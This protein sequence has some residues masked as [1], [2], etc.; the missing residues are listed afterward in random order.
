[1]LSIKV[2]PLVLAP[3]GHEGIYPFKE[4]MLV[5]PVC[6]L[7]IAT[8]CDLRTRTIPDSISVALLLWAIGA[9]WFSAD[10]STWASLGIGALLGLVAGALFF[11]L[12][13]LGGGD[14]KLLTGLGAVL[15]PIALLNVMFWMALAGGA[16]A[17]VAQFRGRRDF[18]YVP[19]IAVGLLIHAVRHGGQVV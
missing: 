17:I 19:A 6:L 1:L 11:A 15:G 3:R 5:V 18:A 2:A 4:V 12:G 13:G 10:G 7:L 8:I 14:V 9:A 16:L